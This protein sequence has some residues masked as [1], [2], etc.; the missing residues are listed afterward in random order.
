MPRKREGTL[1]Y[2]QRSGWN[3]R[4]WVDVKDEATGELREE[5]RWVPLGTHDKDLAKR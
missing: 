5:R 3:A 4:I 2:K 1:V